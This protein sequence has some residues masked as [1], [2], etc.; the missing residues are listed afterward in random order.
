MIGEKLV[1]WYTQNKRDLPWRKTTNPYHIWV[2]EI[3]LQQTQVKKVIP[4]YLR[5][6]KILPTLKNL[7][8]TSEND[9]LNL[10]SGLGY[11]R[12]A[13][14][15]LLGAKLILKNHSGKVPE[16]WSEIRKIPGIGDYTASA[17]LSIAFGKPYSVVDGNV[18]RVSSRL[19]GLKGDPQSKK[20]QEKIR[21]KLQDIIKKYN[22]SD[23]NQGMMELGAL[24]CA[25]ENP[26]C[27]ACPLNKDCFAFGKNLQNELPL[28]ATR[29]K[30]ENLSKIAVIIK[31]KD[32]FLLTKQRKSSYLNDMWLFPEID[33]KDVN[34]FQNKYGLRLKLKAKLGNTKH[35]IT[36]RRMNYTIFEATLQN[37][38]SQRKPFKWIRVNEL[39]QIPH[40]SL[41]QKIAKYLSIRSPGLTGGSS[42]KN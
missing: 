26:Q 19:F 31:N 22:P 38:I 33:S 39:D 25:P 18:I 17:I 23:F 40:S 30:I 1:F 29:Q 6:I 12:R 11:Y 8:E 27:L 9:V 2:S 42:I 35:H 21:T 7:A 14:N 20:F 13:R 15:L 36:F 3:M 24:I 28:K 37:K 16:E 32:R 34:E 41:T 5:F 10:W 4:F